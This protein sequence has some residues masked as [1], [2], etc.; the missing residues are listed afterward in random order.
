MAL[1]FLPPASLDPSFTMSCP[2]EADIDALTR[3]YYDSFSTEPGNTWWWPD[4]RDAMFEWM[5][6]RTRRKISDRNVRHFQVL[7]GQG[8]VVSFARWDIPKGYEAKF[9]EWV[10]GDDGDVSRVVVGDGNEDGAGKPAATT[11][12][13]EEITPA[14]AKTVSAPRGADPELCQ[15]FFTELARLSKKW[16]ATE[17]L[18]L[19]LL[20]TSPKYYRRG[21]AKALLLPM[22]AIADDEGLRCYLE[23]TPAGRPVYE[24]LG[25]ETVEVKE[26]DSG[27]LTGGRVVNADLSLYIMI[28]EPRAL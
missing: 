15:F 18:G 6:D 16:N 28:R 10:G 24:K 4:D 19:S 5:Q 14:A 12:P 13:V 2:T 17:M 9:G 7:D 20:C 23:A 1:P 22:L 3:V 11:A 21:A 26:F 27:A 25:F 8:E